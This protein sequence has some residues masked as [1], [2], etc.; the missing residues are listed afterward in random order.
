MTETKTETRIDT[1]I[2]KIRYIDDIK[3]EEAAAEAAAEAAVAEEQ[4]T[5]DHRLLR[6]EE[7]DPDEYSDFELPAKA[8]Q[9]PEN[10]KKKLGWSWIIIVL[11]ALAI[12]WLEFGV[13]YRPGDPHGLWGSLINLL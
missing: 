8:Q 3:A 9:N 2:E 5:E 10:K 11:A 7:L 13:E 1:Q 4:P 6:P 12:L